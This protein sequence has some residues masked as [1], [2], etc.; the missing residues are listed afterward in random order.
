[1]DKSRVSLIKGIVQPQTTVTI[2]FSGET[3]EAV[4]GETIA[5]AIL[6]AGYS[7]LRISRI[8]K[9]NRSYFCGMGLCWDCAVTITGVGTVRGCMHTVSAGMELSVADKDLLR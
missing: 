6:R 5:S 9:T 4:T 3:I 8:N 1:M 7:T 2:S